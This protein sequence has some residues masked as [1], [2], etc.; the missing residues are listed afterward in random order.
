MSLMKQRDTKQQP[1]MLPGPAVHC[2]CFV[3]SFSC[4]TSTP[5]TLY[6]LYRNRVLNKSDFCRIFTRN[7]KTRIR[8]ALQPQQNHH[9]PH[10][11]EGARAL[12]LVAARRPHQIA[13]SPFRKGSR[14]E[15]ARQ[16]SGKLVITC[17]GPVE[18]WLDR[19]SLGQLS[20]CRPL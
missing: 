19:D 8:P 13:S 14:D 7:R 18:C 11:E 1:S 20:I 2:F 4:A 17:I 9:P 15:I 12:P 3:F 5:S 6:T 10:D 16:C